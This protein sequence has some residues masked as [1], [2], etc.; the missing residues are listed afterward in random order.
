MIILQMFMAITR[1]VLRTKKDKKENRDTTD[2]F[3]L[4]KGNR[5]K[6]VK[7]KCCS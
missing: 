6:P 4:Q 3:K 7:R 1:Q 2:P 5:S